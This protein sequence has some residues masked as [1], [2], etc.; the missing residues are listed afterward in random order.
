MN[1]HLA[2][3]LGV[4]SLPR[5]Y[6]P[7]VSTEGYSPVPAPRMEMRMNVASATTAPWIDANGWRYLRGL[8]KA[9]YLNLPA[10]A[11]PLAAAEAFAYGIEAVIEPAPGDE[12]P[13]AAMLHFLQSVETTELPIRANIGMVDDGS[14]GF[15]EVLNLMGRRNLAYKVVKTPDPKLDLN[16]RLGSPEYPAESAKNPSDFA[17]RVRE[18]LSDSRRVVRIFGT[19]N[20]IA[21]VTGDLQ[22]TRLHLLN[23]GKRPA[24]D[25]RVR[26]AGEFSK[27]IVA[28]A[29]DPSLRPMDQAV[30]NNGTEF[31]VPQITT[32]A[33]VD[34]RR[35]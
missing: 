13:L 18:R 33:V 17:A 35:R 15:E 16:V 34:L 26:V 11:A 7:S 14:P 21:H 1:A 8:K 20:V 2:L 4:A 22:Y 9:S 29:N 27:V 10:G 6:A 3:A 23:Y 24:K 30:A 28:E 25:V 32:Y 5:I 31:T 12:A 19:Y